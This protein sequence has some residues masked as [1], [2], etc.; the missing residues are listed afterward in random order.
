MDEIG[1]GALVALLVALLTAVPVAG[2]I[3]VVMGFLTGS[4]EFFWV[5]KGYTWGRCATIG[6]GAGGFIGAWW[7]RDLTCAGTSRLV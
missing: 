6:A 3:A 7:P 2:L 5:V 1:D 4:G